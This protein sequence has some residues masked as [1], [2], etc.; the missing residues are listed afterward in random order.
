MTKE[1][2]LFV[3]LNGAGSME[4]LAQAKR[5]AAQR[6]AEAEKNAEKAKQIKKIEL[7]KKVQVEK[8]KRDLGDEKKAQEVAAQVD[9]V[10]KGRLA[11]WGSDNNTIEQLTMKAKQVETPAEIRSVGEKLKEAISV[12]EKLEAEGKLVPESKVE[13]KRVVVRNRVLKLAL[14][15]LAHRQ[16][17]EGRGKTEVEAAVKKVNNLLREKAITNNTIPW[18]T[19]V[20]VGKGSQ[21][22]ESTCTG[23]KIEEECTKWEVLTIITKCLTA[24]F[25]AKLDLLNLWI[26]DKKIVRTLVPASPSKVGRGTRDIGKQLREENKD[27]KTGHGFPKLWEGARTTRLTFNTT[28]H[29]EAKKLV[30]KEIMWKGV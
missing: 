29:T 30:E 28:D 27:R 1:V 3:F 8:M 19:I 14:I 23:S 5:K 2:S 20:E 17:I 7:D 25:G 13:E 10:R 12:K 15:F 24:I 9:M 6:K 26:E 21:D 16:A 4:D 18:H 11:A 22:K